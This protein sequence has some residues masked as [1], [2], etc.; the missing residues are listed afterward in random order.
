MI[1]RLLLIGAAVALL[2]AASG[3]NRVWLRERFQAGQSFSQD[4]S[5][6]VNMALK[7]QVDGETQ[8]HKIDYHAREQFVDQVLAVDSGGNLIGVRRHYQQAFENQNGRPHKRWYH[9]RI[10]RLTKNGRQTHVK[11][12][13]A[14]LTEAQRKRLV[15]SLKPVVVLSSGP[16]APGDRWL[17]D[18]TALRRFL[19]LPKKAKARVNCHW[20]RTIPWNERRVALIAAQMKVRLPLETGM[21]LDMVLKGSIRFDLTSRRIVGAVFRGPVKIGGTVK[22]VVARMP[23]TGQGRA[24]IVMVRRDAPQSPAIPV[25]QIPVK[26]GRP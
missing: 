7:Y 1:R 2:T 11:S 8:V 22:V 9:G 14:T 15:G 4:F 13:G 16:V 20:V 18:E 26:A 3:P 21:I 17:L 6:Q 19:V 5:L 25:R 24:R 23:V 12:P 10:V